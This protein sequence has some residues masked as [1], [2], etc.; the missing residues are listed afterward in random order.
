M[1]QVRG[2]SLAAV[3]GVTALARFAAAQLLRTIAEVADYAHGRV[4]HLDR[5][6]RNVLLDETGTPHVADFGL[7]SPADRTGRRQ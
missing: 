5:N 7:A 3:P 4:L 2:D 6:R 1:R